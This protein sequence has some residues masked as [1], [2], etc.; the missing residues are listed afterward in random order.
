MFNY[1]EY[2]SN[3]YKII[4]KII[5]LSE[6]FTFLARRYIFYNTYQPLCSVIEHGLKKAQVDIWNS[7][8]TIGGILL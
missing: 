8:M 1:D 6:S 4:E 2:M 3:G 5:E 7:T